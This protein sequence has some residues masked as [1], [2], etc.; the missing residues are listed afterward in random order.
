LWI[1]IW[2]VTMTLS[3]GCL[4]LILLWRASRCIW[5]RLKRGRG[6]RCGGLILTPEGAVSCPGSSIG[7]P[8]QICLICTLSQSGWPER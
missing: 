6:L 5:R 7:G 1:K 2:L 4:V 8:Q 3:L